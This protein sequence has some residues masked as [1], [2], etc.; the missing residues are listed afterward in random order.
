MEEILIEF[1]STLDA[2]FK[3][4]QGEV[5]ST[6]GISKLTISQFQYINAIHELG[7]PTITEV[8][9]KLAITKASVTAGI[10]KLIKMGYVTKAQSQDDRR[11]FHVSLTETGEQLIDAKYLALKEYGAFINAAL[12]DKEAK[13]F[14][15]IIT[16]LVKLFRQT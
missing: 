15:A 9:D 11:S 2:S 8:A 4:I 14:E 16:K 6:T 7:N 10:D 1:V 5:G 13:Q 3:K 12:S